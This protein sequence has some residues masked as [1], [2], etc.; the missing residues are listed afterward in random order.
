MVTVNQV[1]EQ[2][3]LYFGNE[4]ILHVLATGGWQYIDDVKLYSDIVIDGKEIRVFPIKTKRKG[5]IRLLIVDYK[6]T[7]KSGTNRDDMYISDHEDLLN[8]P[9]LL[10]KFFP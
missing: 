1:K 5:S 10:D 6:F 4:W 3:E 9:Q 2:V 7:R 8:I